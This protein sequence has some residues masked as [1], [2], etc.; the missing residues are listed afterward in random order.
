[1]FSVHPEVQAAYGGPDPGSQLEHSKRYAM[2]GLNELLY[3]TTLPKNLDDEHKWR[4]ALSQFK[5]SRF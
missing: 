4:A 3:F 5:V 2:L 1:M